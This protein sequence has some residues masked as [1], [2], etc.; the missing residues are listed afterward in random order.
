MGDEQRS[1]AV[2]TRLD[3]GAEPVYEDGSPVEVPPEPNPTQPD[4]A[5]DSGGA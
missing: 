2:G 5:L 4:T 3:D 1:N